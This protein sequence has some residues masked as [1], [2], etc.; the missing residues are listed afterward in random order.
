[1]QNYKDFFKGKKIT[2]MGLGLLGGALGDIIFLAECGAQ[3]TV[4][5]LKTATELRSSLNKLKKYKEIKF[6]LGGHKTK[7][8][9]NAD[10]I[11]QPGNVPT[12]SPYLAEARKNKIPIFVSESLFAKCEP[13]VR[14]IGI[15]GTRGKSM[16]TALIYEILSKNIKNR[17][18]FLGGNVR[19]T[20][21]LALLGKVK[22]GDVVV[23]ELDSWALHGM[24]EIKKSPHISIFTSFM[25]DHMNYYENN[26]EKYFDDKANI[27][28]FQKKGDVL[29]VRPHVKKIIPR[30]IKSKLIVADEKGVA[31]YKFIVPGQ[32]QRENLSC[33]VLVARLFKIPDLKIKAVVKKFKGLEGRMQY[34]KT[35]KGVKIFND[36]NATTPEATMA[37]IRALQEENKGG[38]II[39]I[40]GGADKNLEL[41]LYVKV[42]NTFCK[43]IVLIP[44][45]GTNK[46]FQ[47]Y[48]F[49]IP[50]EKAKN[51]KEAMKIALGMTSR[52]DIILF[53]PAFASFG[54]FQNE[55]DRGD[56]FMKIVKELK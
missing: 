27:F 42:V 2:V 33:A 6:T 11:L 4:T 23:M 32:H 51:L 13:G 34:L 40:S 50:N 7:D 19:D 14:M 48:K 44:G 8:F 26:M 39:L 21:T 53:S 1:M 52:G 54:M 29:I 49:K 20:S 47:N 31:D 55:Y 56:Q 16:T 37:D 41:D 35:I 36:N 15:T 38:K 10:M 17:K 24:G 22:S 12:N 43:S 28:K 3:V 46:L 18:I 30:D 5:D 45:T 9:K 25:P